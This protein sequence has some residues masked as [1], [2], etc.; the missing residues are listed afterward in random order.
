MDA[1]AEDDEEF[2]DPSDFDEEDTARSER[3]GAF[4]TAVCLVAATTAASSVAFI[5]SK[6]LAPAVF[7]LHSQDAIY[8]VKGDNVGR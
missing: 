7:A 6:P 5:P 2:L 3:V 4:V 1:D 8:L